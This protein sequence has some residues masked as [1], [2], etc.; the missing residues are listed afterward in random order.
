[1]V[2]P[3][4]NE[5]EELAQSFL[6]GNRNFVTDEICGRS[7]ADAAFISAWIIREWVRL[8]LHADVSALIGCIGRRIED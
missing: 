2:K 6:N 3:T 1:M 4:A 7:P 5:I 8:G